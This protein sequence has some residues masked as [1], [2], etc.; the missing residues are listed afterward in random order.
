[1]RLVTIDSS[2][3]GQSGATIGDEILNLSALKDLRQPTLANWIPN[4]VLGI[5]VGGPGALAVV[6]RLVKTI[7]D[8]SDR[9][10]DRLRERRA[11]TPAAQTPFRAPI[12]CF[13]PAGRICRMT[14]R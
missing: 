10:K 13:R 2:Y 5:I 4:S 14:R 7:E 3:D 9:V 12:P 6:D 11:L 8:A 1:M